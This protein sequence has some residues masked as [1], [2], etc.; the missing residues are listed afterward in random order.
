MRELAEGTIVE[1]AVGDNVTVKHGEPSRSADI[2]E[3]G[4][5]DSCHQ[6]LE[7]VD[8]PAPLHQLSIPTVPN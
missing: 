5:F 3:T 8:D 7:Y 6:L 4:S 1:A 2:S